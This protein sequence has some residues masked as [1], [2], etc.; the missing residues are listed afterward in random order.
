M[1]GFN[2]HK[3]IIQEYKKRM[4]SINSGNNVGW[5]AAEALA[6]ATLVKDGF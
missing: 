2:Y 3:L 6:F 5:A 1:S 4:D